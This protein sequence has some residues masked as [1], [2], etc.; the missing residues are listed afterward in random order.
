MLLFVAA[1]PATAPDVYRSWFTPTVVPNNFTGDVRFEAEITGLSGSVSF[2]YNGVDRPMRDDGTG[3]DRLAGDAVWTCLFTASEVLTRN[4]ANRVHRPVLGTCR[5][6]PTATLNVIAEVWSPPIGL[7]TPTRSGGEFQE[8]D[9]VINYVATRAQLTTFNAAFWANRFYQTHGDKYDFLSFVHIAGVRG[10]RYHSSVRNSVQGIGTAIFNNSAG[11]GSAGRLQGISVFPIPSFYDGGGPGFAHETGHQWINFLSGTPLAGGVPHWPKGNV[12]I[13]VMGFSLPGG[14]GGQFPYT[15]ASNGSGGYVVGTGI[16][17]NLTTFNPMELYLMGLAAPAEV[18]AY[19]VLN[20]QNQNI[21]SGQTLTAT[22][23]TPVTVN[24]VIAAKGPR[25]PNSV[26]SQKLFRCAT[27]ILS[28]QLL[29]AYA[30]SLYDFFTRRA[31]ARQPLSYAEG[32]ASGVSNPFY[33]ATGG[34][35]VMITKIADE[36]PLLVITRLEDGKFRLNFGA[37]MGVSYQ[38]QRSLDLQAW[39]NEGGVIKT[40]VVNP[41]VDP[42]RELMVEPTPGTTQTF[43]RLQALY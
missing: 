37:R 27:I 11:F 14:V 36:R 21:T 15:F 26:D 22:E 18:P 23:I 8:T 29:D 35:A 25:A 30:L 1:C 2:N 19:F 28:E 13:N 34:R 33:V 3:G 7:V 31:E 20:N 12:A 43:Y 10:N 6:S 24:D 40:P 4:T 42:M 41:P 9:Y 5:F 16:P 32:L 39:A 17:A 38:A